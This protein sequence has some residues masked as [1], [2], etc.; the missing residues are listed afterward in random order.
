[1]KRLMTA[2]ASIALIGTLFVGAPK[3]TFAAVNEIYYIGVGGGS[4]TGCGVPDILISA[5]DYIPF[6]GVDDGDDLPN[7]RGGLRDIYEDFHWY[8]L[9]G[10]IAYALTFVDNEDIIQ[11]CESFED[12]DGTSGIWYA[13]NDASLWNGDQNGSEAIIAP[14]DL[15][16]QGLGPD[17]TILSADISGFVRL[18]NFANINLTLRDMTLQSGDANASGDE[19]GGAVFL[20]Y[21]SLTIDNVDFNNFASGG[22]GG[23]FVYVNDADLTVT[24]SYFQNTYS[25]TREVDDATNQGNGGAILSTVTDSTVSNTTVSISNSVFDNLG[26]ADSGGA[27]ALNCANTTI[28]DSVFTDNTAGISGGSIWTDGS[29]ASCDTTGSLTVEN[30]IFDGNHIHEDFGGEGGVGGAVASFGQPVTFIDST[31]GSYSGVGGVGNWNNDGNGGGLFVDGTSGTLLTI[32]DTD[33]FDNSSGW[34]NGGAVYAECANV[35]VTGNATGFFMEDAPMGGPIKS[36]NFHYNYARDNGGAIYLAVEGCGDGIGGT[37]DFVNATIDGVVLL[38]NGSNGQG[39]AIASSQSG[40]NWLKLLDIENSSFLGNYSFNSMGGAVNVD[41]SHVNITE[42]SF[43]G[44]F[45]DGRGGAV[46]VCGGNLTTTDSGFLDNGSWSDGGA[47]D[48]DDGCDR[49]NGGNLT[50][51]DSTFADN[52]AGNNADGGAVY[53]NNGHQTVTIT[54]SE[55]SDNTSGFY[56]G[57][58]VFE[59]ATTNIT[60]S[61]FD[62]N[63]TR[64]H[65]GAIHSDG[66][67][68]LTIRTSTFT[69]NSS[70]YLTDNTKDGGAID[71]RPLDND[72]YLGVFDSVFEDNFATD[73]GGAIWFS[74]Y[75]TPINGLFE[76]ARTSF[77]NN[78][79]K[80]SGGALFVQL[81]DEGTMTIDRS[82]FTSNE[83]ED[84][85]G[86]AMNQDTEDSG[87]FVR[88]TNS[89]FVNNYAYSDGGALDLTDR[90]VL[91]NNV[92]R[93]NEAGVGDAG[94]LELNNGN[95]DSSL[96]YLFTVTGNTFRNNYADEDGGAID[97]DAALLLTN[98]TFDGNTSEDEDGGAVYLTDESAISTWHM[99]SGNRFTNNRTIDEDGGGLYSDANVIVSSNEFANNYAQEDGGALYVSSEARITKNTFVNNRT[100]SHGGAIYATNLGFPDSSITDNLFEGNSAA[101]EGGAM[102]IDDDEGVMDHKVVI[103][104]NRVIRNTA[105][106]GAGIYVTFPSGSTSS[107]QLMSGIIRNS[108]ER[109]VASLNG[110]GIMMEYRGGTFSNARAALAA[111][112][113][114]VKNNRYKANKAN[115]DRATGDIGGWAFTGVMV[116]A[117]EEVEAVKAPEAPSVR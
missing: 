19:R 24:D 112:K 20:N 17:E 115:L 106:Y 86:G 26:T 4:S 78:T 90:A 43:Y 83:S 39:G 60:S 109:N 113:K 16:I 74:L 29:D 117:L 14:I 48:I 30:S 31:V 54:N 91:T 7:Y 57:A 50:V 99:V 88:I 104:S 46:S 44:N 10:A 34:D 71:F 36:S 79:S 81:G 12:Q 103:A 59:D 6:D 80:E 15:T 89:N 94:A 52:G 28:S 77:T 49:P 37:N 93:D 75:A 95:E 73:E 1:M 70:G 25:Y 55:F 85:D 2:L 21:G 13:N 68:S 72:A 108:F 69:D 114:A 56:G 65:G 67:N 11:L 96:L 51:V 45:A 35:V 92:F 100:D 101:G 41:Y 38:E 61:L 63:R 18:F 3:P 66:S 8:D 53:V 97:A 76:I 42:S 107:T 105:Q 33:F 22:G 64:G 98:N 102:W 111:L 27:L 47:I 5:D 23:Q 40:W 84:G 82:S 110:G 87:T 62:G 116:G 32:T 58:L 9:D